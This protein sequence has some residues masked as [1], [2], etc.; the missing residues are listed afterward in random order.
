MDRAFDQLGTCA[1]LVDAGATWG[2]CNDVISG[3][4]GIGFAFAWAG[5][6]RLRSA[7]QQCAVRAASALHQRAQV[8]D[9][10]ADWPMDASLPRRMPNFSHGTSG[11][12]AL[13]SRVSLHADWWSDT[14]FLGPAPKFPHGAARVGADVARLALARLG[15]T[16]KSAERGAAHLIAIADRTNGGFVVGHDTPDN[17]TLMYMGWCHGPC[18]TARLFRELYVATHEDKWRDLELACAKS[19]MTCGLPE[20]RLPGFWNNVSRCCGDAGVIE[21][22]LDL[23]AE[24]KDAQYL[25]FAQ[26]VGRDVLSRATRDE[27][28]MRWVQAEHRVKPELLV[29]QTGLMQ[30][31]AGI[32]LALVHLDE[33]ERGI[34]PVIRLPDE[35][36]R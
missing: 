36:P 21:F 7:D 31:A 3:T 5:E 24:T 23:Y 4:A 14:S 13:L 11:V 25:E 28:G 1:T 6:H 12:A 34:A 26:R 2:D 15:G 33:A 22:M 9:D 17:P 18:G 19:V 32:A 10:R 29:A 20:E 35:P 30:G 16:L 8:L 27:N